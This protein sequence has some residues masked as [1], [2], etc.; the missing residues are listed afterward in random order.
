MFVPAW[1]AK[2]VAEVDPQARIGWVGY[3]D[4]A[5]PWATVQVM[6]CTDDGES[7]QEE[8]PRENGHFALIK[9]IPKRLAE[10]F[11]GGTPWDKRGPIYAKNGSSRPDW[12]VHSRVPYRI[13]NLAK[14]DVYQGRVH[15]FL[16]IWN[17]P[18]EEQ[19]KLDLE[20][21]AKRW[22]DR[23][24]EMSG[25]M[26]D[27]LLWNANKSDSGYSI[28]PNDVEYEDYEAPLENPYREELELRSSLREKA[29]GKTDGGS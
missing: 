8:I 4:A 17:M 25:E 9:L 28:T 13:C 18:W 27:K 26:A 24:G 12:D 21:S 11:N 15:F 5:G 22:D 16:K 29:K 6:R 7:F 14:G 1:V 23:V 20:I 19:Q 10:R 2:K 3:D